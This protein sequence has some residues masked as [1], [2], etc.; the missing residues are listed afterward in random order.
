MYSYFQRLSKY[1]SEVV[2]PN[3]VSGARSPLIWVDQYKKIG[4]RKI[5]LEEN[6][7]F[8]R[9]LVKLQDAMD[10]SSAT[11][12]TS[13]SIAV[14]AAPAPVVP[15]SPGSVRF[16]PIPTIANVDWWKTSAGEQTV[17]LNWDSHT[18]YVWGANRG[19]MK[20]RNPADILGGSGMASVSM[21]A[22]GHG[23]S[24][25][26]GMNTV[27][28][29]GEGNEAVY[30][31]LKAFLL[32]GNNIVFP[33]FKDAFSLGSGSAAD[34]HLKTPKSW[35]QSQAKILLNIER[36][37]KY[38]KGVEYPAAGMTWVDKKQMIGNHVIHSNAEFTALQRSV[39][40][41]A[42]KP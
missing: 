34:N 20:M 12:A 36:L 2:Y 9:L 21:M 18:Y 25:Y 17:W 26:I 4:R 37:F 22:R 31:E 10:S 14:S 39:Q 6:G 5:I 8:P 33:T 23:H 7:G 38:A 1:S 30:Q 28:A 35:Y 29:G 42:D 19:N 15:V 24:H 40:A 11:V 13:A 3:L 41:E 32:A 27:T 16:A